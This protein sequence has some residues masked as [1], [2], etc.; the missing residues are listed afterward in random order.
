[1]SVIVYTCCIALANLG[2]GFYWGFRH[3]ETLLLAELALGE[4]IAPPPSSDATCR[5]TVDIDAGEEAPF[6]ETDSSRDELPA[7]PDEENAQANQAAIANG[8]LDAPQRR[9]GAAWQEVPKQFGEELTRIEQHLPMLRDGVDQRTLQRVIDEL[10]R[11]IERE[12]SAWNQAWEALSHSAAAPTAEQSMLEQ[13]I[14]QAESTLTNLHRLTTAD[15]TT[16]AVVELEKEVIKLRRI[17]TLPAMKAAP[18]PT[19]EH[20]LTS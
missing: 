20:S 13:A 1:M 3:R 17:P 5:S 15:H 2:L 10:S 16:E 9:T 12:L 8:W 4:D 19:G 6:A 7:A 11:V 18:S 14:S